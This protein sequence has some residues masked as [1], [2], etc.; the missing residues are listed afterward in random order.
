M[1]KGARKDQ[2]LIK[3]VNVKKINKWILVTRKLNTTIYDRV[4][5]F[6]NK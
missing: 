6:K 5:I 2:Q 1:A 3:Q 4:D